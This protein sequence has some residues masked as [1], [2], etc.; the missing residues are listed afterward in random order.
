MLGV[1]MDIPGKQIVLDAMSEGLLINCIHDNVLRFLPPYV[2]SDGE[3]DRAL[4]ILGRVLKKATAP[5][6]E[7]E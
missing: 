2:I 6:R 1:E 3:I 7:R 5:N 4:K